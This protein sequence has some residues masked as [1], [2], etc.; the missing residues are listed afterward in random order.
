MVDLINYTVSDL[1]KLNYH[2]EWASLFPVLNQ[3]DTSQWKLA[4]NVSCT[5]LL[6][7]NNIYEFVYGKSFDSGGNDLLSIGGFLHKSYVA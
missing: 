6:V 3:C 2:S 7:R 5:K 4:E 1:N